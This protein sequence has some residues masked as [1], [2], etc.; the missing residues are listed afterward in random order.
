LDD[1]VI[2]VPVKYNLGYKFVFSRN[3][4]NENLCS[5]LR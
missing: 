2:L 3:Y 5:F 1:R 4:A